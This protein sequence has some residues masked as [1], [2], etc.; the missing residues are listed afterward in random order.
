MV[1]VG[2]PHQRQQAEPPLTLQVQLYTHLWYSLQQL[3]PS[4]ETERAL[5]IVW[6]AT[7]A[8]HGEANPTR[9]LQ[10]CATK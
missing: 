8:A 1:N 3:H 6:A 2:C 5:D 4:L 10:G 7:A 9:A